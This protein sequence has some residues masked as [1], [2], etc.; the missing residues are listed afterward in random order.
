M[1]TSVSKSGLTKFRQKAAKYPLW[2]PAEPS[3][4]KR[5][6]ETIDRWRISSA[7]PIA[8]VDIVPLNTR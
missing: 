7:Q 5:F 2:P 3:G 6:V 4:V 8:I 1:T